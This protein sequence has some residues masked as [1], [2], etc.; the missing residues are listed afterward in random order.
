MSSHLY[1]GIPKESD[2]KKLIA[3]KKYLKMDTFS[4]QFLEKNKP[5][6]LSYASKWV[7]NPLRQ[8]S[9]KWEYPYVFDRVSAVLDKNDSAM[10]LDAGS[11][12]SFSH[13]TFCQ[14]IQ[15]SVFIA[16]TMTPSFQMFMLVSIKRPGE[17]C[18]SKLQTCVDWNTQAECSI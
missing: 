1:S 14:S 9:R 12:I 11:G 13:I 15:A 2:Y 7:S 10:I 17:K 5:D 18:S 6:L 16:L 4:L 8:W 3:S